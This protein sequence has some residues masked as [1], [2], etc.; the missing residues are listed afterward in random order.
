M[1]FVPEPARIVVVNSYCGFQNYFRRVDGDFQDGHRVRSL[2]W[3][4]HSSVLSGHDVYSKEYWRQ[5]GQ[6]E[7]MEERCIEAE[8]LEG[9]L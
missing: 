8:M 4:G 9:D 6:S 7:K 2:G 3:I 5:M 1:L